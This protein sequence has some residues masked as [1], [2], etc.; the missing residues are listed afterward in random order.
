MIYMVLGRKYVCVCV[1]ARACNIG[2]EGRENIQVWEIITNLTALF[3]HETCDIGSLQYFLENSKDECHYPNFTE[4][5]SK[6]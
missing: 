6:I 5:K 4:Y 3:E 1:Y 2:K